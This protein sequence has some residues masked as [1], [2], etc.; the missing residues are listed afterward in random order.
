[1]TLNIES[2]KDWPEPH[3]P[4]D[5]S[6]ALDSASQKVQKLWSNITPMARREW[7]CWVNATSVFETR[8]RR[9]DVSI[10]KMKSGK[11]R[12]CCFDPDLTKNSRLISIE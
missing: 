9:V 12:P 11:R 10:S 6:E 5:F 7:V 1:V 3:I 8:E 2:S 4:I